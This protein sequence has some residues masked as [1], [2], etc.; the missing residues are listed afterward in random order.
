M[1]LLQRY[2]ELI[3]ISVTSSNQA[4]IVAALDRTQAILEDLLGYPLD[5]D[6]RVVNH[7]TGVVPTFAYRIFPFREKDTYHHVDPSTEIHAIK[8]LKNGVVEDTLEAAEWTA[9]KDRGIIR[10]F[11]FNE[12]ELLQYSWYPFVKIGFCN[13]GEWQLAVDAEYIFADDALPNDLLSVWFDMIS[14]YSDPKK[15]I[16]SET[17]GS[18]SYTRATP[19]LPESLSQNMAILRR[20]AGPRGS[21]MR[22]NTF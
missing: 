22:N 18:H 2:S 16:K 1:D 7:L 10:Y 12:S 6:Q 11:T 20:Y 17:L 5:P 13:D 21:I 3:G 19:Q 14:Y 4:R 15:E 9:I 8:I